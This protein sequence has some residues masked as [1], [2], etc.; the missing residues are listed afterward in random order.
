MQLILGHNYT[1]ICNET[2]TEYDI[3][4]NSIL[5]YKS[6]SYNI[7]TK[8]WSYDVVTIVDRQNR[9]FLTG[10]VSHVLDYFNTRRIKVSLPEVIDQRIFPTV[11]YQTP[12]LTVELRD[13][14]LDY[15]IQAIKQARCVVECGTGSGKTIMIAAIMSILNLPTL[16][17]A[18]DKTIEGQLATEL[19]KLIINPPTYHIGIARNLCKYPPQE[20]AKY[21]ILIAD[22][23]HTTPAKQAYDTILACGASYRFGFTGS[24]KGRSDGRDIITLGLF[25]SILKL[26]EPTELI[27]QGYLAETQ[28]NFHYCGFE[29]DYAVM[30][31]LLIV[32]NPIRNQLIVDLIKQNPRKTILVLVRRIDHGRILHEM[33]A[34]AYVDNIYIHGDTSSEERERIRERIKNQKGPKILI[35]SNIFA[36]GLDIP[37]LELGVNAAGGKAEI[38]T[39]QKLGRIMRPWK[40]V[41]KQWIDVY[42]TWHPTLERH[43][44]DRIKIYQN[45]GIDVQFHGFPTGKKVELD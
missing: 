37:N 43:S 31:D 25:G 26:I 12:Q 35:A 42:D 17:I 23:A 4:C 27:E 29:G 24:P 8:K 39:G 40:D 18:P 19:N 2:P 20:L 28:V 1:Y 22:E 33:L 6:K 36:T 44:K 45:I 32:K 10:L 13:Y 16:I 9:S 11:E 14:Q 3:L 21:P 5:C 41:C 34:S 30:E 38:L 15:V 7:K